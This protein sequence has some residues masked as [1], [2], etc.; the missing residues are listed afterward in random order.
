MGWAGPQAP[1]TLLSIFVFMIVFV[2]VFVFILDFYCSVRSGRS[3]LVGWAGP[4]AGESLSRPAGH[5]WTNHWYKYFYKY[6]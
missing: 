3:K 1:G 2:F 6:F 5:C 4:Q